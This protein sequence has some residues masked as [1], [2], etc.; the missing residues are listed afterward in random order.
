MRYV[1]FS[2]HIKS[3]KSGVRFTLTA[4]LNSDWP[5]EK[6]LVARYSR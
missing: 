3:S 5:Y 4:H 6:V 1:T 2:F